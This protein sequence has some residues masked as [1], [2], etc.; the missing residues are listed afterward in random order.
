MENNDNRSVVGTEHI[1]EVKEKD[2]YK[3]NLN[4]NVAG[5]LFE[6]YNRCNKGSFFNLK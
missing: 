2:V 5:R 1:V 4:N 6:Y 3:F